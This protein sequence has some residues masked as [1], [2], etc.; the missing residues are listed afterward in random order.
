MPKKAVVYHVDWIAHTYELRERKLKRYGE[1]SPRAS[2][3][4]K[5]WYLPEL[6]E[7]KHRFTGIE[8]KELADYVEKVYAAQ[9]AHGW[10][11][12]I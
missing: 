5:N 1:S 10:V 9:S 2:K 4:F 12:R 3:Y 7:G 8:D 6:N 11:D